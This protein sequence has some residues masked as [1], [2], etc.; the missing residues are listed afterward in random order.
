VDLLKKLNLK[1]EFQMIEKNFPTIRSE[2]RF[3]EP[4]LEYGL[5]L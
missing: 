3:L 4:Y 2:E 5:G 1:T